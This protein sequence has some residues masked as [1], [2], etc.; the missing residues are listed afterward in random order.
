MKEIKIPSLNNENQHINYALVEDTRP[1]MYRALKYWGKKPH[2]IFRKYIETYSKSNEIILD[3]FVGSGITVFEAVQAGRKAIGV[4]LNPVSI[5]LMEQ[6]AKPL[7]F[8]KFKIC[9]DEII[10]K[11]EREEEKCGFFITSC[12]KC[13]QKARIINIHWD[14][15]S[16]MQLRY[17]C[18]CSK[19]NQ[20]KKPEDFDIKLSKDSEKTTIPWWH[21]Q[22]KFPLMKPF[23]PARKYVGEYFFNLWTK[24]SLYLLSYL[25]DEIERIDDVKIKEAMKYAFISMIHLTTKMPSA[26]REKSK[27]P[28]SGSWGRPAYIFP[29]RHLEMNPVISFY[30]SV[31]D[32]QGI[33]KS[34]ESSDKL[35]KNK[36]KLAKNFDEIKNDKNCLLVKENALELSNFIPDNSIDYILTDPPYGGLIQYF[37]LSS[38]WSVWLKGKSQ[39]PY[40]EMN[41]ADEI[42]IDEKKNFEYYHTM[43]TKAL[44]ELYRVLKPGRYLTLTFHNREIN[45]WNS[46]L[47]AGAYSGFIF[48]KIIYQP[49]KRASEAGVAMPYGSAISDYYLRFRKPLSSEKVENRKIASNVF[50]N[51]VLKAA[52]DIII[53]RGEPTEMTFILNGIYVELLSHGEYF[54]GDNE[55]IIDILKTNIDK[56]FVLIE[57]KE[58]EKLGAKWWLKNPDSI[59]HKDIPLS[60]RIERAIIDI[61]KRNFKVTYDEVLKEIF[62]KFANGLTPDSKKILDILKE[63]AEKAGAGKWRYKAQAILRENQHNELIFYLTKLGTNSGFK[64]WIG[65]KEQGEQFEGQRLKDLSSKEL[66]INNLTPH[67][68]SRLKE[69]D[70]IWHRKGSMEYMFEVE[71]TTSITSALE[72]GSNIPSTY[73]CKKIIILPNERKGFLIRKLSEPMFKENFEK[74]SWSISYYDEIINFYRLYKNKDISANKIDVTIK[75]IK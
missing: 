53:K 40:F 49:N 69:V 59:L 30:R 10:N 7:D 12:I 64:V 34:K 15:D 16:I 38:I 8:K 51:I 19:K 21:P 42:T 14:K 31:L 63:Y 52:K 18:S 45:V 36:I 43:L 74:Y 57:N 50:P 1:M 65:S 60:D 41:Y 58:N 71:N 39:D 9:F 46:A 68:I 72:R 37:A 28:D 11:L 5:F 2:N 62:V 13:G 33:I 24:R 6:I 73:K 48:E 26:R 35:L 55:E 17:S 44:K 32:R 3:A 54:E 20:S 56:E 75:A 61:L 29:A 27:R 66:D 22:D 67:Q 4:D 70:V 23:D 25:Y 47:K